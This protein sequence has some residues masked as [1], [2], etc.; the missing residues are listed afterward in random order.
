[1]S[2]CGEMAGNPKAAAILVG[3]GARKLS[4]NYAS[5]PAVKAKLAG[6]TLEEMEGMANQCLTL[7]TEEEIRRYVDDRI[8]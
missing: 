1:M 5:I 6:M 7:R 3:L 8:F 2:V 4:M